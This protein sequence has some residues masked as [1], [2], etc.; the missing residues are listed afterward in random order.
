MDTLRIAEIEQR[1][2]SDYRL[3]Y[4]PEVTSTNDVALEMARAGAP[5]AVLVCTDFQTAGRGRRGAVW[6]SSPGAGALL[7][8]LVRVPAMLPPLHL[9]ITTGVGVAEG[10]Q[11]LDA[12][13][14]IKWPNDI[15]LEDRK[16]AGILVE[17][18][19]DAV[20]VGVGINCAVPEDAFPP[21][22]RERAGSL[23]ALLG[24]PFPRETVIAAVVQGLAGAFARVTEGGIVK[25]LYA[26]NKMN[27][28]ARRKVRVTGPFG[29]VEGD[30]LFLDGHKV[31]WH[32]FKD[33][34]VVPMPLSS[35]VEVR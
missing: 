13:V 20:V 26:W 34:G 19:G 22:L 28:Y 29:A 32:V 15:L 16:V 27:W 10:L 17:T 5:G 25:A 31:V 33:C 14:K 18:H 4:T 30:G 24:R 1:L 35:S 7:S 8:L 2:G 9:A 23:D 11:T 21:E 6:T 12:P 3:V